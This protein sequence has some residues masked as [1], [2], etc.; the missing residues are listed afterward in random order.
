M[1]SPALEIK[2]LHAGY[3]DAKVLR[4]VTLSLPPRSLVALVGANGAGKTT[5]L[6]TISGLL[7][8]SGGAIA[9]GGV[10][11]DGLSPHRVVDAG[12][13]QSPDGK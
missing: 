12:F 1:S 8:K 2:D 7:K 13:V 5:L 6:R 4:G 3:G 11:I 10:T 9:L